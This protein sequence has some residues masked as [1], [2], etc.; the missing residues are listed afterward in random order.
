M[1]SVYIYNFFFIL[2]IK[3]FC[4]T[5]RPLRSF[6]LFKNNVVYKHNDEKLQ[7]LAVDDCAVSC[8]MEETFDCQSF[9]YCT[10]TELCY[11]SKIQPDVNSTLLVQSSTCNLYSSMYN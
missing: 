5:G 4:I 6:S 3:Q 8:L 7:G 9:E 1:N 11:L 2:K 10:A